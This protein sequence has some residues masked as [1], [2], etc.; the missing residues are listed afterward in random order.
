MLYS[1]KDLVRKMGQKWSDNSYV[2]QFSVDFS[3]LFSQFSCWTT[4]EPDLQLFS[5]S[6]FWQLRKSLLTA[7]PFWKDET[8]AVSQE[9]FNPYESSAEYHRWNVFTLA[10]I[11]FDDMA[12]RIIWFMHRSFNLM[13]ER[14]SK[15]QKANKF[16]MCKT[17]VKTFQQQNFAEC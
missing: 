10:G 16:I 12:D 11:W 1:K 7:G 13:F 9:L 4:R 14:L 17:D 3:W 2:G 6:Y 5:E 15:S 8:Y